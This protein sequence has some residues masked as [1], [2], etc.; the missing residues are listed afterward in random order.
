MLSLL[1]LLSAGCRLVGVGRR[2]GRRWDVLEAQRAAD[3]RREDDAE[4]DAADDDH[5]LLLQDQTRKRGWWTAGVAAEATSGESS[6]G[7]RYRCSPDVGP[8]EIKG[9]CFS[10]DR[11]LQQ[12]SPQQVW[13]ICFTLDVLTDATWA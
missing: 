10:F 9:R 5:D 3:G 7:S 13:W 12:G 1:F 8:I 11:S 6:T 4:D 2:G